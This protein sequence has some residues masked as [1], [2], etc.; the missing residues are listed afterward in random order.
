MAKIFGQ[1]NR[2]IVYLGEAAD[3]SDQALEGIRVAA[4]GE[5]PNVIV[6]EM[7]QRPILE[8][9]KRPWFQRIW[10]S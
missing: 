2:V 9:L 1:A 6:N 7:D 4:E 8:L 5:S 3:D 10:A